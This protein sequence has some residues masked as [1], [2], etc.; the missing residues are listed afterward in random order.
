MQNRIKRLYYVTASYPFGTGESFITAEIAEWVSRGYDVWVIPTYRRGYLRGKGEW[1]GRLLDCPTFAPKHVWACLAWFVWKPGKT[2]SLLALMV[3]SPRNCA[4]NALVILKAFG[5]AKTLRFENAAHIHAHWAGTSST[6]AMALSQLTGIPWSLTCHR[7]DIYTNNLLTVKSRAARFVRF[8]SE[9]GRT[10]AIAMGVDARKCTVIHMGVDAAACA[11][12]RCAP[13]NIPTIACPANLIEVKGHR[14]LI[15]AISLLEEM[16][17]PVRLRIYGDGR[18]RWTLE[19]QSV[20]LSIGDRI[21]FMGHRPHSELISAYLAGEVD[22]VVLPS[23]DLGSG[24]HEGIP[25]SLIEAMSF[26][27][28]VIS[29]QT[30]SIEELLPRELGLTVPACDPAALARAL[31]KLLDDADYYLRTARTVLQIVSEHWLVSGSVDN[32]ESRISGVCS[33]AWRRERS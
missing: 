14:Y 6:M 11:P 15:A 13:G 2:L 27:I 25:V 30:G 16:G 21:A 20:N 18:L 22:A 3:R 12:V 28:P 23:V 26:G 1:A 10:D 5:L 24:N 4:K 29:T 32:L 8:I 7:W 31:I 19:Q 17:R 9:R 33:V